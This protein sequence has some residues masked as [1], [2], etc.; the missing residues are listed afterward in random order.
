MTL[1]PLAGLFVVALLTDGRESFWTLTGI[2]IVVWALVDTV[3]T[4]V[5]RRRVNRC[6]KGEARGRRWRSWPA[7][8]DRA[9]V[10]ASAVGLPAAVLWLLVGDSY[11]A[12]VVGLFLVNPLLVPLQI[13]E[14]RRLD[15]LADRHWAATSAR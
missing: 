6:L 13:R 8:S 3:E 10:I 2:S 7:I 9:R 5:R 14:L 12:P 15:A 1:L 11:T 4:V